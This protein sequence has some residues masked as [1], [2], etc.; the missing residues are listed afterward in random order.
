MCCVPAMF[1][2]L[3]PEAA[4][5]GYSPAY[6]PTGLVARVATCYLPTAHLLRGWP[7]SVQ[8]VHAQILSCGFQLQFPTPNYYAEL[9]SN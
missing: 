3:Q 9:L 6:S 2:P 4:L 8:A 1:A 7:R 5:M